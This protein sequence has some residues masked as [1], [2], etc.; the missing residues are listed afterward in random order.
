MAAYKNNFM[1]GE[2]EYVDDPFVGGFLDAAISAGRSGDMMQYYITQHNF[3][4]AML[5]RGL[6]DPDSR[7]RAFRTLQTL[8]SASRRELMRSL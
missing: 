3:I 7:D 1:S 5:R 8:E 4:V 2:R 6:I